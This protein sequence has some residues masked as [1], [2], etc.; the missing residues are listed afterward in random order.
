MKKIILSLLIVSAILTSS[1]FY[2]L[3]NDSY[4]IVNTELSD[5]KS[6]VNA[7]GGTISDYDLACY[8]T[9]ITTL[10]DGG[11]WSDDLEIGFF[12]Y[13]FNTSFI[14]LKYVTVDTCINHGFVSG[15]YDTLT[16]FTGNGSSKWID[17][18]YDLSST[19]VRNISYGFYSHDDGNKGCGM[20]TSTNNKSYVCYT[21]SAGRV[22][23]AY[24]APNQFDVA[25]MKGLISISSDV[26]GSA[27]YQNAYLRG[28][29]TNGNP[30]NNPIGGGMSLFR[31]NNGAAGTYFNGKI[32]M[33]F[34]S[35]SLSAQDMEVLSN[36]IDNFYNSIGRRKNKRVVI[37]GDSETWGQAASTKAKRYASIFADSMKM[38]GVV[39]GFSGT[40]WQIDPY[41]SSGRGRFIPDILSQKYATTDFKVVIAYGLNDVFYS[42][43]SV[44][45]FCT[46]YRYG[47]KYLIRHGVDTSDICVVNPFYVDSIN[48][49]SSAAPYNAGSKTLHRQVNDSCYAIA[50]SFGVRY[51]DSYNYMIAN[52]GNSLLSA[53][54]IHMNDSGNLVAGNKL[55]LI[56]K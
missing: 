6:K 23:K 16:G 14:K 50:T 19:D 55:Y 15:D 54:K 21:T 52:G 3:H 22:S 1:V 36:A 18:N 10:K 8:D 27:V 12:D 11:V 13:G 51:F 7:K 2:N 39:S 5:Y 38:E 49:Y 42:G 31:Y 40:L 9:L 48:G 46:Q 32:S 29:K 25:P 35:S 41:S 17:L 20:G 4:S 34:I 44:S 53:D 24:I 28:E 37:I 45:N 30:T 43:A 26:N 47:L 33:Y 56:C